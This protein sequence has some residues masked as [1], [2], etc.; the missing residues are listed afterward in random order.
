MMD[1]ISGFPIESPNVF[2]PWGISESQLKS[3]LVEHGLKQVTHGYY[4]LSCVSLDGLSHQL[5]FHFHPRHRGTLNEL[6]FFRRSYES[7]K[8]S[9]DDFQKHF[10]QSF[11]K[12]KIEESETEGYPAFSWSLNGVK[13]VHY[14]IERFGPE[15]HMRIMKV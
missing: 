10:E 5:G 4:T 11:G 15:E 14:V 1:L 12:P 2:V 6:E 13:I 9:F 3:L 7:L 8:V